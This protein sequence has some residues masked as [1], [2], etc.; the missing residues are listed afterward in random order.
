MFVKYR[1]F[2]WIFTFL[3]VVVSSAAGGW[4]QVSEL[5]TLRVAKATA[6]VDDKIY[7]IGGINEN[8]NLGGGAPALSR[9]DVYDTLTNTWQKAA[10]MLTPRIAP[11]AAVFSSDIYVFGGYNRMAVRGEVHKKIVEM[12][13]TRTDTWVKKRDMPTLRRNF[14]TAV[15]DGKIYIIGGSVHDKKL[16]KQVSTDL[17]EVYDPLTNR[18]KNRADMPTKRGR[19]NVAVVDGKIYVI[20]G[21]ILLQQGLGLLVDRFSKR[22]EEYNPKINRWRKLPDMP[23]F[24]YA[25]STVVVDH[26]IYTIGGYDMDNSLKRLDI[27]EVYNPKF[28]RWRPSVPML[29]PKLTVAAVANGTIYLLGG[30]GESGRFSPVV[31]AY[32]TGFRAVDAEG[33]LST[34]WGELKKSDKR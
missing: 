12:Y 14:G 21:H 15:V 31:E 19:I 34:R 7:L 20:G 9:V 27:V 8:E 26:E 6:A 32:D 33:K 24:K 13:D 5:P 1:H 11:K 4:L 3:F 28:N 16:G 29:M 10:D 25:F 23:M 22:I 30:R 17:V 2:Q 18:W